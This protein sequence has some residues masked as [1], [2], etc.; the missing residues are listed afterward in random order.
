[1][2]AHARATRRVN[3]STF[4]ETLRAFTID[5]VI[6]FLIPYRGNETNCPVVAE[7]DEGQ[8]LFPVGR[9]TWRMTKLVTRPTVVIVFRNCDTEVPWDMVTRKCLDTISLYT[10]LC[11]QFQEVEWTLSDAESKVALDQMN[12]R[13]LSRVTNELPI[14]FNDVRCFYSEN[15]FKVQ[16]LFPVYRM[17]RVCFR[18]T[19][20]TWPLKISS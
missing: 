6:V 5:A 12:N 4:Y 16:I 9:V 13:V 3:S 8:T 20:I 18:S 2:S 7:H 1:M 15:S 11:E 19:D 14:I 10:T 17:N